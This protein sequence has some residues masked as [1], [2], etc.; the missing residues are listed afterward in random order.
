MAHQPSVRPAVPP[1]SQAASNAAAALQGA[2]LA[3]ARTTAPR[4]IPPAKREPQP[5]PSPVP[6]PADDRRHRRHHRARPPASSRLEPAARLS[7]SSAAKPTS[8]DTKSP[9]YIAATLAASRSASPSPNANTPVPCLPVARRRTSVNSLSGASSLDLPD[10]SS[11]APTTNLISMFERREDEDNGNGDDVEPMKKR[12]PVR[13][14]TA[15]RR[16]PQ[17]RAMTPEREIS[18]QGRRTPPVRDPGSLATEE[19]TP[20][21]R[22]KPRVKPKLRPMTPERKMSPDRREPGSPL[23][24]EL[25]PPSN[26][27]PHVKARPGLAET[28]ARPRPVETQAGEEAAAKPRAPSPPKP[29]RAVMAPLRLT[30]RHAPE[31]RPPQPQ[32]GQRVPDVSLRLGAPETA[33]NADR[34][35]SNGQALAAKSKPPPSLPPTP[36]TTSSPKPVLVPKTRK[37]RP[38][39]I[40]MPPPRIISR[41]ATAVLSPVPTRPASQAKLRPPTPPQPRGASSTAKPAAPPRATAPL[42]VNDANLAA[43]SNGRRLSTTAR[44]TTSGTSSSNETF[45]SASSTQT[46]RPASPIPRRELP[47]RPSS[48]TSMPV[49]SPTRPYTPSFPRRHPAAV[50]TSSLPVHS[51]SNAIMAGSLAA[52]RLTPS[53][54]GASGHSPAPPLPRRHHAKSPRLRQTLRQPAAQSDDEETRRKKKHHG[55]HSNK[56]H[57]HH[58]GARRRWREEMTPRERKRYEAL[59][60]SNRGLLHE[61]MLPGPRAVGAA[62]LV[63]NVVVREIWRRS[64]LPDDELG[65]VWDLVVGQSAGALPPGML[66]KQ[67]F[68]VG[69][70]VVD[71]RLKGRKIPAKVGASVWDSAK[72]V[73]VWTPKAKEARRK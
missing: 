51:L 41:S 32:K 52:A 71:Q 33:T 25:T 27:N 59:W 43:L 3:F 56:K 46:P 2:N 16:V 17:L 63:L 10:T 48:T 39:S 13:R 66:G 42:T 65:E 12:T 60:A 36:P 9:S 19:T 50:S 21:A 18:P 38:E 29:M 68:V 4:P 62:D 61:T 72:G 14:P 49:G 1:P 26:P 44:P 34:S 45:V 20:T 70:W 54:T 8:Y 53:N 5:Q 15:M 47:P 6:E 40:E 35:N 24:S 30:Q 67:E 73:R 58:E 28:E 64:R 11:I 37:H 7:P 31:T 57:F 55:S 23:R 69:T 22:A